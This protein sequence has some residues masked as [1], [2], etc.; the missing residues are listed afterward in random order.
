MGDKGR[1]D[2]GEHLKNALRTPRAVH[3]LEDKKG[4]NV[5]RRGARCL[6]RRT[7]QPT[8]GNKKGYR[9]RQKE[10]RPSAKGKTLRK[11]DAPSN[12]GKQEGVQWETRPLER[13]THHPHREPTRGTMGN[14]LG[15]ASN[16]GK[17]E[18]VQSETRGDKTVGKANT[19]SNKGSQ[20]GAQWEAQGDKTLRKADAPSRYNGQWETK[21]NKKEGVQWE[22][23]GDK[24]LGKAGTPFNTKAAIVR[25]HK[26][27][28]T[29]HRLATKKGDKAR[30]GESTC[31]LGK[32][33][34]P[35]NKGKQE[36]VKGESTGEKRSQDSQEADTIQQRETRR[37]TRRETKRETRGDKTLGKAGTPSNGEIGD[38]RGDKGTQGETRGHKGRQD[39]REGGRTPANKGKLGETRPSGR[40]MQHPTK[41]S[42]KGDNG[43]TI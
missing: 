18:G 29:V 8:K 10:T 40:R 13:R 30:Q 3:C 7:H 19:P 43:E 4:D 12:K 5:E 17:Q 28:L 37:E 25:K 11:A 22:T 9:R 1:Q 20:E 42:R 41:G 24:T 23:S 35:A 21:G 38:T 2:Q 15:K 26:E 16:K 31:P 36:A 33:D 39:P 14:T 27:P 6:G 32:A 34:T